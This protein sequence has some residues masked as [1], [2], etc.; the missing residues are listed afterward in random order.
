VDSSLAPLLGFVQE[1]TGGNP[2][3]VEEVVRALVEDGTLVGEPGRYRLT[4]PLHELKVPP[5]VQAVLAARIDRLPAE[6]KAILQTASI[7]GRTFN[8]AILEAVSGSTSDELEDTLSSLCAAEMLQEAAHDPVIEYRFWHPLTQEVAS[9]SLLSD[10]R[11]QLHTAV[12]EAL[13]AQ[14]GDRLDELAAVVAWHWERAGRR[15]EAA[16]WNMRAGSWALRRD[17]ADARRRWQATLDQ[18]AMVEESHDSLELGVRAR[19]R[20]MQFGAR[21]GIDPTEAEQLY[22]QARALVERLGDPGLLAGLVMISGSPMFM[23]GDLRGACARYAEGCRLLEALPEPGPRAAAGMAIALI[24]AYTGPLPEGVEGAERALKICAEDVERGTEVVGYSVFVRTLQLYAGL[25]ALAGRLGDA[26][27]RLEQAL[28]LARPR[29]EAENLAWALA[30]SAQLAWLRG[31]DDDSFPSAS[32]ALSIAEQTGDL[33]SLVVAL[34][35]LALAHL[36]AGRPTEAAGA[37][38]RALVEARGRHCGLFEEGN[39]LA[40]LARAR[41]AARDSAGAASAAEEAVAVARHQGAPVVECLAILTRAQVWRA[42][43]RTGDAEA[44]LAAALVLVKEAGALTYEPFIREERSRLHHDD[45][46]LQEALRLYAAI[47]ATGHVR[48]LKAELAESRRAA[49]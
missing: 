43:G 46:E 35:A 22:T 21:T 7:I 49:K 32:E 23:A 33:V 38:E 8:T 15:L 34:E 13:E 4:R 17:L 40:H 44:D 47:G 31:D 2:F 42:T 25:L 41:L 48:R 6:H 1:R 27:S 14:N 24:S 45:G 9:G 12:A 3:F 29:A 36:L 16:R 28:T 26:T 30:S 10:R 11:G 20:L 5:S 37:C 18:L 19:I 39:L